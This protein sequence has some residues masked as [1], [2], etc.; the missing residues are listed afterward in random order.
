MLYEGNLYMDTSKVT[1]IQRE[2]S[3]WR[4]MKMILNMTMILLIMKLTMTPQIN[5]MTNTGNIF[6]KN[7][8][9]QPIG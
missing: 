1:A 9:N 5:L 3:K 7:T 2:E 8:E 6:T 4:Y